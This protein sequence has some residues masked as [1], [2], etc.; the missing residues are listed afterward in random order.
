MFNV[1]SVAHPLESTVRILSEATQR[2]P[3]EIAREIAIVDND[4]LKRL[5]SSLGE[6]VPKPRLVLLRA[7][8]D[9][10]AEKTFS[11]RFWAKEVA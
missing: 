7:E 5:V 3:E 8:L 2:A 6:S 11:P 1:A 10:K 9:A 4:A